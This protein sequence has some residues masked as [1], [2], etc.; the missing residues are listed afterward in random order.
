[1][2]L[3]IAGDPNTGLPNANAGVLGGGEGGEEYGEE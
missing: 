1:M 3:I 2:N